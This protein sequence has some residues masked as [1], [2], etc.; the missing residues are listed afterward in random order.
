M[1]ATNSHNDS[2]N[3]RQPVSD[4]Q[5]WVIFISMCMA[6]F[7]V[8]FAT[9]ATTNAMV[10]IRRQMH[11]D[12]SQLQW[13]TNAYILAASVLMVLGGLLSDRYGRRNMNFLG[14]VIFIIGSIVCATS[15]VG[16]QF[17][18]GRFIQGVGVAVIMPGTLALMKVVFPEDEQGMVSTGWAASIGLGMGLGPFFSGVFCESIGWEYLF[19]LIA[20]VMAMAITLLIVA[21]HGRCKTNLNLTID[22]LGLSVFLVGFSFFVYAIVE[23]PSVGW[24]NTLIVCFLIIGVLLMLCQPWVERHVHKTPFINFEYFKRPRFALGSIGMFINGYVLIALLF[25]GNLYLQNPILLNYSPY[26][27]GLAVIPMGFGLAVAVLFVE[28]LYEKVGIPMC[29]QL[30]FIIMLMSAIW[31]ICLGVHTSYA[32]VWG[33]FFLS[34]VGCGMATKAFPAMAIQ[35]LSKDEAARSASVVSAFM[36]VGVI[37]STAIGTVISLAVTRAN[38]LYLTSHINESATLKLQFETAVLSHPNKIQSILS[39]L[40]HDVVHMFKLSGEMAALK[41][42]HFAMLALLGFVAVAM[43]A[44]NILLRMKPYNPNQ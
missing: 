18:V 28:K 22:Y 40:P 13:T 39:E 19:A 10:P 44:T 12:S 30:T 36:Y 1:E 3:D 37:F 2:S 25:F 17:I 24:G 8:A 38:F 14:G 6:I 34:G 41:G 11:L 4:R 32:Y 16:W 42:F 9:T 35:A 26:Q 43:F 29:L 33:P 31:F 7:I 15:T 21:L 5:K 20:I 27:A 23:G